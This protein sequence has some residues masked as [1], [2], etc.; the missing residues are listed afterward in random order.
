MPPIGFDLLLLT[1]P[2]TRLFSARCFVPH[3]PHGYRPGLS[4]LAPAQPS[5]PSGSPN[6]LI[7]G[8]P[9]WEPLANAP[10]TDGRAQ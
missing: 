6:L 3:R 5:I 7:A 4:D 8:S 9:L 10:T 1:W 2:V